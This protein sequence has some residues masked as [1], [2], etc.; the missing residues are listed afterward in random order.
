[1]A[2][3]AEP[4]ST[5]EMDDAGFEHDL[6]HAALAK[7]LN[8]WF[9]NEIM[10]WEPLVPDNTDLVTAN[11]WF[12]TVGTPTTE[13]TVVLVAGEAGLDEKFERVLKCVTDAANEGFKQTYTYADQPR[14]K[15]GKIVSALVWVATTAGGS[16]IT[17]KL[18]NSDATETAGTVVETDG[19][20]SLIAI[21]NHTLA[22]TSCALQVTKD[23]SG[24]FYAYPVSLH[25]GKV[26][27]AL[28]PRGTRWVDKSDPVVVKDLSGLGDEATWTDI[29]VTADASPLAVR[30]RLL[31]N[32][33]DVTAGDGFDL[34]FRRNGSTAAVGNT[35][36]VNTHPTVT[37]TVRIANEHTML[38]DDA[39][40]FEY[41]LDRWAGAGTLSEGFVLLRA[42]EVW[43]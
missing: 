2:L 12:D 25:L 41:H 1:M 22:G 24:T 23:A 9:Q 19:D 27:M 29:D 38:L 6:L 33:M 8:G 42:Y 11:Q 35:T 16:G 4:L 30:A 21:Q 18:V 14:L 15:L 36:V 5:T 13:A 7:V 17:A 26:P 3:H 37:G 39:Q 40:I 34:A 28:P 43:E 31:T 10:G 32:I 20:F